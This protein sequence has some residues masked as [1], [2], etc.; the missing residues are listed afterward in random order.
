ME[1]SLL[2]AEC[3]SAGWGLLVMKLM[4]HFDE[5]CVGSFHFDGKTSQCIHMLYIMCQSNG[6]CWCVT[7][8]GTFCFLSLGISVIYMALF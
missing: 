5:D 1:Q 4:L 2:L 8:R 3:I 6:S 7:A